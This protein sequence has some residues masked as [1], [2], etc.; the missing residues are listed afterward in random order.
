MSKPQKDH[1]DSAVRPM[2]M[3]FAALVLLLVVAVAGTAFYV[4]RRLESIEERLTDRPPKQY[5]APN[6]E[7]Y[8]ATDFSE[9]GIT[10]ERAVYVPTYS[11]VY[12]FGGRPYS[13]EATLSIR[14]T[15][16]R[17]PVFLRSVRYYDTAGEL[18]TTFVDRVI[19]LD[20]LETIEFV[21]EQRDSKGGSGANFIVQWLAMEQIDEPIVEAVMV[22]TAGTQGISFRSQGKTLTHAV[23]MEQ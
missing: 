20:A 9:E 14:N 8:A 16:V 17:R 19:K 12:H 10:L 6:L 1:A 4:D 22:G 13:L 23:I 5:Q 18:V 2:G 15:D 3:G 11:H 7:D 21:V